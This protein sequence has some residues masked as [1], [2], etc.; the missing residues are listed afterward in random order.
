MP[1]VIKHPDVRRSELLDQALGL[2]LSRGYDNTSLNDVIAEAGMSKGAF[3][4]Y[5]PSKEALLVAIADR[6]GRQTLAELE[7]VFNAPDLDPLGRLNAFL[8]QALRIKT[9]MAP[10]AWIVFGALFRPENQLL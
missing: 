5:F 1:R 10:A 8:G 9:D 3:Y 2:Y 7:D 6:F 4:H